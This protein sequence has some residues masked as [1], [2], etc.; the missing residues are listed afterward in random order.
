MKGHEQ[1]SRVREVKNYKKCERSVS[2]CE[3]HLGLPAGSYPPLGGGRQ[4]LFLQML[5]ET[6]STF[7]WQP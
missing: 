1:G 5:T 2:P 7:C 6:D 3:T 4:E